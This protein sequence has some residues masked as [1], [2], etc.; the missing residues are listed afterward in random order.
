MALFA[1]NKE[2]IPLLGDYLFGRLSI[3]HPLMVRNFHT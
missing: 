2:I 1:A 3:L